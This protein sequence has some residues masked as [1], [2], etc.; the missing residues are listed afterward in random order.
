MS[1]LSNEQIQDLKSRVTSDLSMLGKIYKS[2]KDEYQHRSVDYNL[3]DD[4]LKDGWEE[5]GELKTK[6]RIRKRKSHSKQF[7]DDI[8]CQLYELGYRTLNFDENFDLPFSKDANDKKQI[9]VIAINED[10]ILIFECKSSSTRKNAPTYKDEFDVLSL[11]M[12]GHVKALKQIFGNEKKVRFIFATRNLRLSKD[13]DDY[14]RLEN[15][16]AYYY[17]DNTYDYVNNLILKYKNASLY[18][19]QGLIFKNQIINSNKIEVPALRGKMGNKE[20][21]MFSIEPSILLKLGFIL[22]RTRA[23]EAE[24]PT[25]QRLLVPSRLNGITKFID[26]GGYFPNS[27]IINFNTKK[28]KI[29]FEGNSRLG[30]SKSVAGILKIPNAYAIAYIIDGQHRVYGY[31]NSMFSNSNTIPVVAFNNLDS[32]EQ[33]KIFMDINQN[34][35]AVSPSLRLDLEEDLYWDSDRADSRLKALKSSI[36]KN[37]ANEPSSPLF[38]KISV[39]EDRSELAFKPFYSALS[40]SGL[41]PTARNN[42]YDD[43]SLIGSL[44]DVSNHDSSKEMHRT[45]RDISNLLIYAYDLVAREYPAIFEDTSSLII[46]NRGTYA[47]VSIIGSFNKHATLNGEVHKNTDVK[48]RYQ[49]LEKYLLVLMDKINKMSDDEK[50]VLLGKLGAGADTD[51]LRHFQLLVNRSLPAYSPNELEDWKERQDEA[52]Q[53]VGR[54]HVVFI[55]RKIK[56]LILNNLQVLF[57][58]NWDLEINSIKRDCIKRAEEERER[59]Y[60]EGLGNTKTEWTDMFTINDYRSI[61]SKFWTQLPK[62]MDT[63]NFKNFE[64]LF[65]INIGGDFNSKSEK[66]KWMSYLNSYRNLVAHEGTKGKGLNSDEVK[67]LDLVAEHFATL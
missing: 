44:Y 46:S 21:F 51:W 3:L 54:K 32:D 59:N 7:E 27:I 18:Q 14:K 65:S 34:Q 67:F 31:A 48:T 29:V 6:T 30:D 61:V 15:V 16:N 1:F 4:F 56:E 40:S 20:Y 41:L 11:R 13:S 2:R 9:D 38:K 64:K 50:D 47:F 57:G 60:K 35:K 66:L 5:D 23:N 45:K 24:F 63:A 62:D 22:H 12:E 58:E 26:E 36:I 37:I 42:K 33:L 52:L 43:E 25:Y 49:I 55:E 17:N 8:W 53:V 28:H 19:F 10:S 39:G